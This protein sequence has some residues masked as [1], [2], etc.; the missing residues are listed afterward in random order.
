[1]QIPDDLIPGLLDHTG[2]VLIYLVNGEAQRGFILRENEFVTSWQELLEAG[3]QAGFPFFN[4]RVI[5]L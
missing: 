2:P 4:V 1:M 3:K 5:Q